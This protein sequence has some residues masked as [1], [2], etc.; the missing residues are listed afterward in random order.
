MSDAK[1]NKDAS[2]APPAIL[3]LLPGT[4][5]WWL[6]LRHEPTTDGQAGLL[7]SQGRSRIA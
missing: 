5:P 2:A 3:A 1:Q 7:P 4:Q 6:L